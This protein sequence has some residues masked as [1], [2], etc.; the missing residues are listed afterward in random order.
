MPPLWFASK[1]SQRVAQLLFER[2]EQVQAAGMLCLWR[3]RFG[4]KGAP[5]A[6]S[7]PGI[8]RGDR[9]FLFAEVSFC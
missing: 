5:A 3:A 6:L 8:E 9:T 2:G 7:W 1:L 4:P